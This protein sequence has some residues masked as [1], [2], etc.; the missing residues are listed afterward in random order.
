MPSVRGSRSKRVLK[1][2]FASKALDFRLTFKKAGFG[3]AALCSSNPEK[4]SR[5]SVVPGRRSL[6]QCCLLQCCRFF[7][8]LD[9]KRRRAFVL[10]VRV[11]LLRMLVARDS[12]VF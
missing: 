11:Y 1:N 7:L 12:K 6:K 5:R 3:G 2:C 9:M 10:V 4:G 8:R